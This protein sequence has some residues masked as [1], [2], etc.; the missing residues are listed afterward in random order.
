MLL[1]NRLSIANS[2]TV[3]PTRTPETTQFFTK[4]QTREPQVKEVVDLLV[5]ED[6]NYTPI[7]DGGWHRL[8]RKRTS[9]PAVPG[10]QKAAPHGPMGEFTGVQSRGPGYWKP[11]L[12]T[13]LATEK[14]AD[15]LAPAPKS[16][17]VAALIGGNERV[18]AVARDLLDPLMGLGAVYIL[19]VQCDNP[20]MDCPLEPYKAKHTA[21]VGPRVFDLQYSL[22]SKDSYTYSLKKMLR[23]VPRPQLDYVYIDADLE[24]HRDGFA[25]FLVDKMLAV[26]GILEFAGASDTLQDQA[27]KHDLFTTGQ[28]QSAQVASVLDLLV[29]PSGRYEELVQDHSFRKLA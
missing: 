8:F 3:N 2:P 7:N 24:W 22:L 27:D 5:A 10:D 9:A 18:A 4:Q 15:V 14:P 29:R 28:L 11:L 26:N 1:T 20:A 23:T 17:L 19:D 25:F 13:I 12:E 16:S 21:H 6:P